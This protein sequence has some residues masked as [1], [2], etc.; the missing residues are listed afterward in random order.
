MPVPL[1]MSVEIGYHKLKDPKDFEGVCIQ[2]FRPSVPAEEHWLGE[3]IY[4]FLEPNGWYWARRWPFK[5]HLPRTGSPDGIV[6]TEIDTSEALDL[7]NNEVRSFAHKI[8]NN[9]KLKL[10]FAGIQPSDGAAFKLLFK[11]GGSKKLIGFEPT[12]IIANFDKSYEASRVYQSLVFVDV[13]EMEIRRTAQIQG[14]VL[15]S[16]VLGKLSL[17]DASG[18]PL[19]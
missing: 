4:F 10:K 2:G 19:V 16:K 13:S 18:N 9:I 17:C 8:V 11:D 3:G 1:G 5:D 14:C 12:C 6:R 7:R 15:N